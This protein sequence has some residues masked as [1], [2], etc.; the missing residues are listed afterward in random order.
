MNYITFPL[1]KKRLPILFLQTVRNF[2]MKNEQKKIVLWLAS[3]RK[4][5]HCHDSLLCIDISLQKSWD[6]AKKKK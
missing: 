2:I 6:T 5:S 4:I 1:T 3:I